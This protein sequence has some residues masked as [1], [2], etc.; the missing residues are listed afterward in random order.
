M[1]FIDE[2]RIIGSRIPTLKEQKLVTTEEGTKN[3]LVM[4]FIRAMGYDVF[5][6]LE[7]TPEYGADLSLTGIKKGE[8]VD[9]AIM[10][11]GKP[12]ILFECKC[13][14]T[15]LKAEHGSQLMRYFSASGV[16]FGI[17][18]DGVVYHFYADLDAPNKIGPPP[19]K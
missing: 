17:L 1:D 12:I 4:P 5:N 2:L 13:C 11:D 10:R 19:L 14:G 8:K 16:R 9:Y 3:A 18:T 6:P 15:D 7:V